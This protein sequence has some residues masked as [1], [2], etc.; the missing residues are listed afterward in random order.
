MY[1]T[2]IL[3]YVGPLTLFKGYSFYG[4]FFFNYIYLKYYL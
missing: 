1:I 2:F 3:K 4:V